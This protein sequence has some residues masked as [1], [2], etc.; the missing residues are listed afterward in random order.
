[1]GDRA[2]LLFC[3]VV[4]STLRTQSLGDE[5]ARQLWVDHDRR[6]RDLLRTHRG[7]EIDRADGFFLLFDSAVDAAHHAQQYHDAL[8]ALGLKARVG[9]HVGAV[10]LRHATPEE[11]AQGAK[12]IEVEGLAKPLAARVMAMA[13]GGQTLLTDAARAAIEPDLDD[14]LQIESHGHY[15]LKGIAQPVAVFELGPRDGGAF[16]P[17][18]DTDKTYR[19]VLA[20]GL[21]VPVRDVRHNVPPER[22]AFIGRGAELRQ[23]AQRFDGGA[24]LL[25]LL[26]PGGTGKTRLIKRYALG[27]LG[28]WPGG[29]VFCDLSDARSLDGIQFAAA[30]AFDCRLESG[31]ATEQ[32]GQAI[33]RRGRCLVVLD[34]FEQVVAHAAA[35]LGRWLDAAPEAAFAVTSR[36]RLQLPGEEVFAIEPLPPEDDGIELFAARARA[37]RLDFAIDSGNRASVAEVVR[38]LDGLPLAIELAAARVSVLSPAQLVARMRDRFR[39]LGGARSAASRQATLRAAIDWSWDLLAPWEQAALAQC[40]VFEG[41]FTIEAAEAVLDLTAWPDAPSEIDVIQAMVDKSLLRRW[42]PASAHARHDLDEPYFGMYITIHEYAAEKCRQCGAT[43]ERDTQLRHARHYAGLGTDEAIEALSIH[44]GTRRHHALQ[45]EIDNL[46]VALRRAIDRGDADTVVPLYRAA[47][48]AL[49]FQ[50]PFG[51]GVTLGREVCEMPGIAETPRQLARLSMVEASTRMGQTECLSEQFTEML[52]SARLLGERKLEGRIL[53]KLGT[54]RLWEGKPNEAEVHYAAALAIFR[55]LGTRLFEGRMC[56]N[57][58]IAY[59]EQGLIVEAR[60]HY[61]DA[62]AI[63]REL[64]SRRDEAVTLTNLADLVSHGDGRNALAQLRQALAILRELGDHDSEANT[65]STLGE[66]ELDIGHLDEALHALRAGLALSRELGNRMV[67]GYCLKGVAATLLERGE[68]G[69]A[70]LLLEQVL[71]S[72]GSA[73]NQRLEG[74]SLEVLADLQLRQGRTDEAAITIARGETLLR[75]LNQKPILVRLLCTKGLLQ[76]AT[77][78]TADARSTLGEAQALAQA[79]AVTVDSGIGRR[80]GALQRALDST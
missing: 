77:A 49:A 53:G 80:I 73:P 66:I 50:G 61:G 68:H 42:V 48:E 65:L 47:W 71:T 36:E 20:D 38:L 11:V 52:A 10:T 25:T 64:G 26:G 79:M 22:D 75:D 24:R 13:R 55:S 17:P 2:A 12:P 41:G 74:F 60:Q 63:W 18:P 44:G 39:L 4:D 70:H 19:V 69:E 57:L 15:R 8:A 72:L 78:R 56:G 51:L 54:M 9:L 23:L 76:A 30:R 32:L 62:L 67:E 58:A 33:A 21:W 7:R 28:D 27:W 43:F 29:V 34:N 14:A 46:L 40:S 35:T 31:D 6:A 37:Q 16:A 5:R 45:L 3:D 1:M 59:H